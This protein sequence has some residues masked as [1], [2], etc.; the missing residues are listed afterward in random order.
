M[1]D[2]LLA[3]PAGFAESC[4][5]I[6]ALVASGPATAAILQQ[7]VSASAAA[8]A[9]ATATAG[10]ATSAS[11]TAAVSAARHIIGAARK[12]AVDARVFRKQLEAHTD[13]SPESMDALLRLY[14]EA[15]S[16]DTAATASSSPSALLSSLTGRPGDAREEIVGLEWA[17]GTATHTSAAAGIAQPFAVLQLRLRDTATGAVRL[18]A[19]EAQLNQVAALEATLHEA[20]AAL[21]RS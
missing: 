17:L 1:D 4:A 18:Q 11:A 9:S 20:A 2:A 3:G 6:N 8:A 21:E 13:L 12:A 14:A 5:A 10:S 7:A 16:S 15:A 19:F